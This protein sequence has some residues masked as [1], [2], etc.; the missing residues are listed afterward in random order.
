VSKTTAATLAELKRAGYPFNPTRH[1]NWYGGILASLLAK[2]HHTDRID[3]LAERTLKQMDILTRGNRRVVILKQVEKA[4]RSLCGKNVLNQYKPDRVR[5]QHGV[6]QTK[7]DRYLAGE[8]LPWAEEEAAVAAGETSEDDCEGDSEADVAEVIAAQNDGPDSPP[9]TPV[10][11]DESL[12]IMPVGLPHLQPVVGPDPEAIPLALRGGRSDRGDP[13]MSPAASKALSLLLLSGSGQL[14][15]QIT[16]NPP[17]DSTGPLGAPVGSPTVTSSLLTPYIE[18]IRA[19]DPTVRIRTQFARQAILIVGLGCEIDIEWRRTGEV[20]A[21]VCFPSESLNNV[22]RHI[23]ATWADLRVAVDPQGRP[24]VQRMMPSATAP[25][26][27]AVALLR[28]VQ[29]L[30]DA[31]GT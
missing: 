15:A 1:S 31:M 3:L 6:S 10:D 24:G 28:D 27:L 26:D 2:N 17:E 11:D 18:A 20:R 9:P 29:T 12:S 8:P 14:G 19:I 30:D 13:L 5:F 16:T 7:I 23:G 22:L 4:I 25:A 21:F